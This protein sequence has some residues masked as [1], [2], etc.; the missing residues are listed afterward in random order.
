MT[1]HDH[2]AKIYFIGLEHLTKTASGRVMQGNRALHDV[3]LRDVDRH[4]RGNYKR[5]F[6]REGY[7]LVLF[8]MG[9]NKVLIYNA[10]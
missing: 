1:L 6:E 4:V 10:R 7:S 9:K 8:S 2:K 3:M 5:T